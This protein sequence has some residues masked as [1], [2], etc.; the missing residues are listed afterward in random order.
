[1]AIL[2]D[3]KV[4]LRVTTNDA[5][6]T[7]EISDLINEAVLDLERTTDIK[8]I[9][10][11]SLDALEKGAIKTYC[12]WKWTGDEKLKVSYDEYKAK[13]S[14]SY[15]YRYTEYIPFNTPPIPR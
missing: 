15:A 5:G 6:L 9:N 14:M 13:M 7:A 8:E 3:V 1:M 10:L 4:A 2:D 11:N 12:K